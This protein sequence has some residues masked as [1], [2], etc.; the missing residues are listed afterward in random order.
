MHCQSS[1]ALPQAFLTK[2]LANSAVTMGCTEQ[3][4]ADDDKSYSEMRRLS[5]LTDRLT[6]RC[7]RAVN[8]GGLVFVGANSKTAGPEQVD[9]FNKSHMSK[10]PQI[11]HF[12]F[13]S[14]PKVLR[15]DG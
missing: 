15:M 7:L 8:N 9:G 2:Q 4:A 3:L 10:A 11:S 1:A 5:L 13:G 14:L 6:C 12:G